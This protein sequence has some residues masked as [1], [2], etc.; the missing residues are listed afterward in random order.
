MFT[1]Y[2]ITTAAPF[3][4]GLADPVEVSQAA[5]HHRTPWWARLVWGA[6]TTDLSGPLAVEAE[7][8]RS[9]T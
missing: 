1:T 3:L 4:D 9:E 5:G 8:R 6:A 2:S 7:N